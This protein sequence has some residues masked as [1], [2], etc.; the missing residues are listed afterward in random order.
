MFDVMTSKGSGICQK[1]N[2]LEKAG[3]AAGVLAEDNIQIWRQLEADIL[4]VS[5][6]IDYNTLKWHSDRLQSHR[7][8]HILTVFFVDPFDQTA[9]VRV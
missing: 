9:T 1:M 7:H 4:Q 6:M 8:N 3:F 2:R 5:D